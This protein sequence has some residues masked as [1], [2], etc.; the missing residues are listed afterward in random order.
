MRIHTALTAAVLA[1]GCSSDSNSPQVLVPQPA[2]AQS[3]PIDGLVDFAALPPA[4]VASLPF[5]ELKGGAP[6][7]ET[8]VL[9]YA[10]TND[11]RELY[12]ALEW[13]DATHDQVFLAGPGPVDCDGVQVQFDVDGDGV[14]LDGEDQRTVVAASIS[15]V[16]ID[17]HAMAP[18]GAM[19]AVGDGQGKL[20]YDATL[21]VYRCELRF[22]LSQDANEEDGQ[23]SASSRFNV[24]LFDHVQVLQ[25]TGS[26]A[27]LFGSGPTGTSS[28]TWKKVPLKSKG[29]FEHLDP[30]SDLTGLIAFAAEMPRGAPEIFVYDPATG[31]STQVT[32]EPSVWKRD[33]SLSHDR[34]EIAFSGS[35]S[36]DAAETFEIYRVDVSGTNLVALTSNRL[37]DVQPSWAPDDLHIAYASQREATFSIVVMQPDGTEVADLSPRGGDDTDPAYLPDGRIV[38]QTNRFSA[39]PERRIALMDGDGANLQQVTSF[40][41]ASDYDPSGDLAVAL[42]SRFPKSTSPVFDP[43]A[44]FVSWP[45]VEV[46]LDGSGETALIDDGWVNRGPVY[47]PTGQYLAY[48]KAQGYQDVHI[49]TRTGQDLGRLVPHQ[50]RVLSVDWK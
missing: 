25:S 42:L 2:L 38:F 33:V 34:T 16:Y 14:V 46:G 20:S 12:M 28:A 15:S 37:A 22:P 3:Q 41:G 9:R 40:K 44:G 39:P 24:L 50:T 11:D 30:P 21:G 45:L 23:L 10:F 35:T 18:G 4:S 27:R 7:G 8:T 13:D 48:V 47:D 29:L 26:I 5:L 19:D 43:E 36:P 17:G 49:A 31:L 1:A 6:T 32:F